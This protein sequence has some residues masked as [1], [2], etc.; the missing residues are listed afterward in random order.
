MGEPL[1]AV[2]TKPLFVHQYVYRAVKKDELARILSARRFENVRE[3]ET[4][5]FSSTPEGAVAYAKAAYS[6]LPDEGPFPAAS[7]IH[8]PFGRML[9]AP[10]VE[11]KS[12]LP[13]QF[14][15]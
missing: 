14:R 2:K 6:K 11:F 10:L 5:R 13:C 9:W 15:R 7:V 1:G 12:F 8:S 4:K 3:I